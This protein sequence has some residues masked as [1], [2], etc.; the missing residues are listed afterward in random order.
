MTANDANEVQVDDQVPYPER[1]KVSKKDG[2]D[3]SV[4][5]M[6]SDLKNN[7]NKFYVV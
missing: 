6:M 1:Y 5:L 4:Y 2:K 3:F 7:H